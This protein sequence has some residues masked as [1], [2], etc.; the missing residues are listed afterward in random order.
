MLKHIRSAALA[1]AIALF[2]LFAVSCSEPEH[3]VRIT[4]ADGT[5]IPAD[6][7][8]LSALGP[9]SLKAQIKADASANQVAW[10]IAGSETGENN[11]AGTVAGDGAS[12]AVLKAGSILGANARVV[13]KVRRRVC[14]D[15]IQGVCRQHGSPF[16]WNHVADTDRR[17]GNF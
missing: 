7:I 8:E 5:A 10:E 13:T 17:L 14:G 3:Q 1:A 4:Y 11:K 15:Q 2:A 6:G 16:R 12:G 9:V